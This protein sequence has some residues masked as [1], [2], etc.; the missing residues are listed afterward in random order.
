MI[1]LP[2]RV[3]R[4]IGITSVTLTSAAFGGYI[5]YGAA[6]GPWPT[7]R[8]AALAGIA[9]V[10]V[11]VGA[12]ALLQDATAPLR[13]LTN[14]TGSGAQPE[15]SPATA[16]EGLT[17]LREAVCVDAALRAA[18]DSFEI[19]YGRKLLGEPDRWQG[20]PDGTA[21]TLLAP[22]A[23]LR[24]RRDSEADGVTA[25]RKTFTFVTGEADNSVRI[26]SLSQLQQLT[27][28]YAAR[29]ADGHDTDSTAT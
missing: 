4:A 3:A 26:I 22:G 29:T 17:R 13:H 16:H 18:A 12:E 20:Y 11:A 5:G 21:V 15:I 23:Y 24:Y 9:A 19:D 25:P 10:T 27:A 8:K 2:R 1:T 14:S 7:G 6:P 28:D